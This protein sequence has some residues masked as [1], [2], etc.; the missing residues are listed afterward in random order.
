[1]QTSNPETDHGVIQGA[2]SRQLSLVYI[3]QKAN[4]WY[5]NWQIIVVLKNQKV[6]L[7]FFFW[8]GGIIWAE[9]L[10]IQEKKENNI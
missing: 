3:F 5:V 4:E 10:F 9:E 6:V 1:M 2:L 7:E 8:K